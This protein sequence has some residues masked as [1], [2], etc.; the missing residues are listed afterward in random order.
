VKAG[1]TK[2]LIELLFAV[3]SR[4]TAAGLK[5]SPLNTQAIATVQALAL[6]FTDNT[7]IVS[8]AS[9]VIIGIEWY[10][11]TIATS[12]LR[13]TDVYASIATA[14]TIFVIS[15][16]HTVTRATCLGG[17]GV[18]FVAASSAIEIIIAEKIYA[19]PTGL[20][21]LTTV[22]VLSWIIQI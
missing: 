18:A 1:Y 17:G 7:A 2:T 13:I 22:V 11:L 12:K 5:G 8:T 10:T 16:S 14:V 9:A 20:R 3:C 19:S 15:D 21:I 6:L 4:T